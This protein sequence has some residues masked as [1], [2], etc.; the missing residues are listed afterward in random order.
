M[1]LILKQN[2]TSQVKPLQSEVSGDF[3][4]PSVLRSEEGLRVRLTTL[5]TL[6]TLILYKLS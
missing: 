5:P 4:G 3:E 1:L 2:W 6:V